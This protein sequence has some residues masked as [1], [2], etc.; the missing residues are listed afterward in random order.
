M[1]NTDGIYEKLKVNPNNLFPD[2]NFLDI[3]INQM[4]SYIK[5]YKRSYCTDC[6]FLSCH[7]RV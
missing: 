3:N 5:I 2:Q 7:V 6:M 4:I 1:T